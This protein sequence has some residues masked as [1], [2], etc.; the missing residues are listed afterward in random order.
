VSAHLLVVH[1]PIDLVVVTSTKV[2]H[3]VLVPAENTDTAH[4]IQPQQLGSD[5]CW[6]TRKGCSPRSKALPN[7][8]VCHG[9]WCLPPMG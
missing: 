5:C 9:R 8:G 4:D 3:D 7:T 6:I 1:G 2:H